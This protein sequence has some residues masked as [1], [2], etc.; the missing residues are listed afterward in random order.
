[1]I[2]SRVL[3]RRL[4]AITLLLAF[5]V[6]SAFFWND[7]QPSALDLGVNLGAAGF[8][9]LF[10]HWRWRLQERRAM[11]PQKVRDIFS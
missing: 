9:F 5:A 10:L 7:G 11:T 3:K 2:R 4:L 8:G 6:G 1:M